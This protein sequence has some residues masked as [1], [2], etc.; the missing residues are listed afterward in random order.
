MKRKGSQ[1][2]VVVR[3]NFLDLALT[4]ALIVER[5]GYR[6]L[7]VSDPAEPFSRLC[8]APDL[9][10]TFWGTRWDCTPNRYA[11]SSSAYVSECIKKEVPFIIVTRDVQ[12]VPVE[13]HEQAKAVITK[14]YH[15][16]DLLSA[17]RK[18][19]N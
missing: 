7:L 12:V 10:L 5:M 9:V 18:A 6:A 17:V 8:E 19:L 3:D 14:P 16:P 1:K 11:A 13:V 4:H 15:L 2:L